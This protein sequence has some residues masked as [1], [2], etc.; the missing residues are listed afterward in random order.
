MSFMGRNQCRLA[1]IHDKNKLRLCFC[2]AIGCRYFD[3]RHHR[4]SFKTSVHIALA[5]ARA[6]GFFVFS[7]SFPYF[8]SIFP[9]LVLSF[10]IIDL[11]ML[12]FTSSLIFILLAGGW[13]AE[14]AARRNV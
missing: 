13:A 2:G 9:V 1:I 12:R 11:L 3:L 8:F 5:I 14:R 10:L 4:V 6:T 7:L